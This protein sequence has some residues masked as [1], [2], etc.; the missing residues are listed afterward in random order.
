MRIIK[1]GFLLGACL[2]VAA[3]HG[4]K[5]SNARK[6][7]RHLYKFDDGRI[8]YQDSNMIWWYIIMTNNMTA[9]QSIQYANT[10]GNVGGWSRGPAPKAS[11]LEEADDLGEEPVE[12]ANDA[13]GIV[14][15][16]AQEAA[17]DVSE[18]Q[19]DSDAGDSAGSAD[20]GSGGDSGGVAG[21][22]E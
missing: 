13:E 17:G 21:G 11:E 19:A 12:N 15:E 22:A 20:S 6:H 5:Q 16:A 7:E 2:A 4:D 8:G 9:Q 1:L 18:A 10:P 3:C 14:D